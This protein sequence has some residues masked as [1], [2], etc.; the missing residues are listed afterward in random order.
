MELASLHPG[1]AM[2]KVRDSTGWDL[3]VADD[4]SL[5]PAPTD[6]ELRLIRVELDPGGAYTR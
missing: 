1:V 6:E 2:E 5:T 3:K 4:L